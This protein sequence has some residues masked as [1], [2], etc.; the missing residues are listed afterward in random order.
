[1]LLGNTACPL[2]GKV[3]LKDTRTEAQS[4][5]T[6]LRSLIDR[7]LTEMASPSAECSGMVKTL[8]VPRGIL[9]DH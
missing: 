5:V 7:Q 4:P 6:P 3:A 9:V 2:Q 8:L 1:M